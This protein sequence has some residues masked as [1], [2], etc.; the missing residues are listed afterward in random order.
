MVNRNVCHQTQTRIAEPL[1]VHDILIHN[2]RLQ[3][4]LCRQV[5][6]LDCPSLRFESDDVLGPMH[7]STVRVD[8]PF[9]DFIVVLEVDD[10]H[11][12][13]VIFAKFLA[14]TEVVIRF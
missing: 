11:L 7:D 2:R 9:D 13:L 8:R 1:P 5:E 3:L 6:D 10:N 4:L 12:G 14:N